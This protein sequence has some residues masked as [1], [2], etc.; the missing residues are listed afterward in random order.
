MRD[1][2]ESMERTLGWCVHLYTAAGAFCGFMALMALWESQVTHAFL[3]MAI[4]TLIDATDGAMARRLEVSRRVPVIDGRRLD[5][6]VDYFNYV[7]VPVALLMF[8]GILPSH[9]LGACPLIASALGFAN[10]QAK[11]DDHYFLGFPSYWNIVALYLWLFSFPT[12][13]ATFI[14]IALSVMVLVPVRYIYP[15]RTRPLRPLTLVLAYTWG[16]QVVA[17]LI[18]PQL[19]PAWRWSSLAFPVYYVVA[20]LV[21]HFRAGRVAPAITSA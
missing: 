4:A 6:I 5:D 14:V 20:S 8:T 7:V 2:R 13:L 19:G 16:V 11:T 18:W 15:T 17:Q 21:L 9:W 10:Q 1:D 3:W 12:A